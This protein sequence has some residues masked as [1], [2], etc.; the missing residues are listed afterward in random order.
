MLT[1]SS[2]S[3]YGLLQE[4]YKPLKLWLYLLSEFVS[5]LSWDQQGY[6]SY[7][8]TRFTHRVQGACE[9]GEFAVATVAAEISLGVEFVEVMS[10]MTVQ[11]ACQ[12]DPSWLAITAHTRTTC[13]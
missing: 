9:G 11:R 7:R 2:L 6:H 3:G 5:S 13:I 8:V 12:T 10:I 1:S 4:Q